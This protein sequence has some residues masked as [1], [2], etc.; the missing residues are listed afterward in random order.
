M[1]HFSDFP[2]VGY[3]HAKSGVL[4]AEASFSR[5]VPVSKPH[6]AGSLQEPSDR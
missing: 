6:W 2:E 3:K 5:K 1:L 4:G